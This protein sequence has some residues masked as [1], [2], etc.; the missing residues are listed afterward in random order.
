[1]FNGT[2][3]NLI[4]CRVQGECYEPSRYVIAVSGCTAA[5]PPQ[6]PP[7]PQSGGPGGRDRY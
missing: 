1:M 4:D 3:G 7:P 5:P 2:C 6:T